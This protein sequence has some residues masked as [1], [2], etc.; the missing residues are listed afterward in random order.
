MGKYNSVELNNEYHNL[1]ILYR[2]LFHK[3][4]QE[5]ESKLAQG[6]SVEQLE[7]S[8][9]QKWQAELS[10]ISQNR[11]NFECVSCGICCRFAVSEFS[12]DELK[13]KAANGDKFASQFVQT[14]IP[15]ES[16]EQAKKVFPQY[17]E[18]LEKQ[19]I[20]D[21]FVYHCPKVTED[22]RCPD[23][24]NRPQICRDFPDNPIAFLP[25]SCGFNSWK[26]QS[27]SVL[28]KLNAEREII[29]FYLKE[30]K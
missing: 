7:N 24:E 26:L 29:N 12:P 22:N 18:M 25:I 13:M 27:E 17:I 16:I 2:S 30:L 6:I 21:F 20:N 1:K 28:L 3:S 9:K 5:I 14:F 10:Q 15:Y 23:Y 19:G 11:A 4:T 8:Y